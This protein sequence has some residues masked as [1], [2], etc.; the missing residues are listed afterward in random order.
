MCKVLDLQAQPVPALVEP[1]LDEIEGGQ[2]C[3]TA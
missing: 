3:P 2:V 1:T